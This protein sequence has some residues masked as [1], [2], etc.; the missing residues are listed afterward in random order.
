MK[1]KKIRTAIASFLAMTTVVACLGG[2]AGAGNSGETGNNTGNEASVSTDSNSATGNN[3][4]STSANTDDS[5]NQSNSSDASDSSADASSAASETSSTNASTDAGDTTNVGKETMRDITPTELVA[6]M[7]TGWNLGNTFDAWSEGK[8]SLSDETSWGNPKTTKEMIDAVKDKGFNTIRIPVTWAGHMGSA[9]DYTVDEE[10]IERVE[11]VVNYC[12]DDGMYVILNSHHEESW[13]IPDNAH[14]DAVDEQH[15]A[16]WTQIAT[17]F[18]KYGDHLIFE[19]LNEP[20]VKGGENEWN[21]GTSEG[22]QCLDRLNQSFVDVVRATGGNNEKRLLLITSFASSA[23]TTTIA[24]LKIP[25]DD[26]LGVSIHAYTPYQF[27]YHTGDASEQFVWDGSAKMDIIN[28]MSDLK[29]FFIDKGIPV[30]L[31]E[32]GAVDKDKNNEEVCKWVTEYLTRAKNVGIPCV[33]WDN[34]LYNT[35]NEYFSIFNRRE[36]TWYRED[37]ADTIVGMYKD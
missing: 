37:V 26:H 14:I 6:E 27:T 30:I 29:R 19:G 17:H 21:G 2:C 22:R 31:T 1:K 23:S 32:Y 33:W 3:D 13:R 25:E 18:E 35:G 11:E 34:G 36:L 5:A 12:L 8:G 16:L 28:V 20:R 15:R 9:P 24:C 4:S 10:W 7:T